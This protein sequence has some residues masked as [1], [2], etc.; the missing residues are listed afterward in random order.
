MLLTNWTNNNYEIWTSKVSNRDKHVR[1]SSVWLVEAFHCTT[2]HSFNKILPRNL[3][4]QVDARTS[5]NCNNPGGKKPWLPTLHISTMYIYDLI[6]HVT[7]RRGDRTVCYAS[8]WWDRG[9]RVWISLWDESHIGV[10]ETKLSSYPHCDPKRF[11][12][13]ARRCCSAEGCTTRSSGI[14]SL[15]QR[16]T[17]QTQQL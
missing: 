7:G 5:V 11:N 4:C 3:I 12:C 8:F 10:G 15:R 6:W 17:P 1:M 13:S 16:S 14:G 9:G 2:C